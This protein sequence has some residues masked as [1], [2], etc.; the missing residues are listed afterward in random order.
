M[1]ADGSRKAMKHIQIGELL[2]SDRGPTKVTSVFRFSGSNTPMVSIGGLILSKEHYVRYADKWIQAAEHPD[3]IPSPSLPELVCLNVEHHR[4]VIINDTRRMIV[5][6]Y[7]EHDGAEVIRQ[8]Q[9][10]AIKSLNGSCRRN[11]ETAADYS[12]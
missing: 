6:D 7:D 10:L 3:A 11:E 9:Q 8:T 2:E 1:M 12:L 5:A 4:F